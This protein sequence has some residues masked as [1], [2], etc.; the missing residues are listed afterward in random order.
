M[1]RIFRFVAISCVVALASCSSYKNVPYMQNINEANNYT[2]L[3]QLYDARIMPKD[4]LT[5]TVNTSD[6]RASEPFNLIVQANNNGSS[7]NNLSTQRSL[8]PY[9]VDNNGDIVMPIIGTVH[10]GGMTKT[11]A[12]SM[13]RE[14]LA[15]LLKETPVVTVRMPN[16]K[17]SVLG[18][19]ARPGQFTI[20]NE[21]V[22]IL[23]ALALAGDMTIYGVRD[24][25]KLVREDATGRKQIHVLNINDANIINSPYYQ[26]QQNDV[27]YIT[28]NATKAKNSE[29][30]QTTSLWFSATSI[31][32][33]LSSLLYNIFK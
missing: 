20:T 2:A 31:L 14:K 19:V 32:L 28:P 10:V 8:L 1:R 18:E 22:N 26:L 15:P 11:E 21:K 6:Q 23:E 25:I 29:V 16:F 27:V 17:I 13:L 5:I 33:S 12:E 24:S 3:T 4:L 7:S 30:G 9:L